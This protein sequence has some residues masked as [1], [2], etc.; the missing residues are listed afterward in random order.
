MSDLRRLSK[1]AGVESNELL[2][3]AFVV[4][5]P[6]DVAAKLRAAARIEEMSLSATIDQARVLMTEYVKD[7][8]AA[9]AVLVKDVPEA[10]VRQH[11]GRTR[12]CHRCD[13]PHL[14]RNCANPAQKDIECWTCQKKGHISRNCPEQGNARG[15]A[16]APAAFPQHQ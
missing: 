9:A 6:S 14:M 11:N 2:Q 15:K 13:G 5:L 8:A 10:K 7:N 16:G 4:G 1:L 3:K 12:W